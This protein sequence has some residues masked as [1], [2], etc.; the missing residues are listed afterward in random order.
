MFGGDQRYNIGVKTM[1]LFVRGFG[2]LRRHFHLDNA[3]ACRQ[4]PKWFIAWVESLE[5]RYAPAD[6]RVTT[7]SDTPVFGQTT[8]RQAIGEL[9]AGQQNNIYFNVTGTINLTQPLVLE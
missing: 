9:V 6:L 2:W 1:F 5:G 8:L 7:L 3:A 4:R